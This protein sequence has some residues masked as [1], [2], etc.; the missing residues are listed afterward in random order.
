ME[1][2]KGLSGQE[3]TKSRE[4]YGSNR[5]AE[6]ERPTFLKKFAEKFDDP[7]IIILLA[8]LGINIVFTFLGKVDWF[9]CAG[10]FLSV[11]IATL[12]GAF[13]EFKNE[14]AFQRI[15]AEASKIKCKV[16]RDFALTEVLIDEVVA[17]DFVLLQAG[18]MVP[19]DGRVYSGS[20]KVDQ[21]ALNGENK[22]TEKSMSRAKSSKA[23]ET[24]DF[25][26]KSTLFRGTVVCSGQC[27]MQVEQVGEK[28]VYG[29]FSGE[30]HDG[31]R[32]SPLQ[33]KLSALAKKISYFGYAGAGTVALVCMLENIFAN[34]ISGAAHYFAD[35]MQ[36]VSDLVSSAIM[37][38]T[39]IVVAVPEG[40]PLMV[41]IVCSLNMKKMLKSNVLVRKLIGIETAGSINILF[42]DKTGTITC[43]KLKAVSF[44][45]GSGKTCGSFAGIKEPLRKLL[46]TSV[47]YNSAAHISGERILGGNATEKA[48]LKF[49]RYGGRGKLN[50]KKHRELLFSSEKKFSATELRG[51]FSGVLVKGAP[52]RIL[53]N[54]TG[55]YDENGER[56]SLESAHNLEKCIEDMAKRC[57]RV[58]AVAIAESFDGEHLPSQ[59]TLVGLVGIRDD[60]RPDVR[61]AVSEMKRAGIQTVMI[62]GDKKETATAIA[63][64]AG[65]IDNT[66]DVVITS[67]EMQKMTDSQLEELLPRLRVVA[68]AL[69]TDKSR[70]VRIA[71]GMGLVAGMTGDGVND[72]S[73]LR[74]AD[75]GFAM[76]GG[77]DI[78]KEAGDIV[79]MDDNFASIKKAVLYGRT[80][81]KSIKK[82]VAFQ[83]TINIAAMSVLVLGP[84]IGIEKPL[85]VIQMLWVNL[86]MDTLAAIAFGGEGA[87]ARYMLEKPKRRDEDIIDKKMWS[88]ITVNSFFICAVSVF[89]FIS[90]D[91]HYAFHASGADVVFYTGYFNYFVFSCI[92]NAFNTRTDSIDLAEHISLNKPFLIIILLICAVQIAMTCFGGAI[93]GTANLAANE[94]A[95]VIVMALLIIPVDIIRKLLVRKI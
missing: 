24:I 2:I 70:L 59:M 28:T 50:V 49:V 52:E 8:A 27:V 26:D 81:Y 3:V 19:A 86:V 63:R 77:T 76:G 36:L 10:I 6:K 40:L 54:C 71:Q 41:A 4:L 22:E 48:L 42:S 39:V 21:S 12:V 74:M 80:I 53:R 16:Y 84:I 89:M 62:T 88:A 69:P 35:K 68:R 56:Q 13:S 82:F 58:L 33:V 30:E 73:A 93:I 47:I 15:Q 9:E 75:V 85:G 14:E 66:G 18:D 44:T 64:E 45:D 17:G 37:G 43:G 60:L 34:G 87:L 61:T 92:F 83:M 38:I 55:Y 11:M 31:Q 79:I 91:M 94:W 78:A 20:V 25:W 1:E 95:L 7:I 32:K 23:S 67:D 46:H 51:E 5:L 57:I 72:L 65:I 90:Q 29:R